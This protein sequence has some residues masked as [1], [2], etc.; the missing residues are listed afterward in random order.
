MNSCLGLKVR[1]KAIRSLECFPV[2]PVTFY[3][4]WQNRVIQ[5]PQAEYLLKKSRFLIYQETNK[6]I[7]S[8]WNICFG[9]NTCLSLKMEWATWRFGDS[10][11]WR[12]HGSS[13]PFP[14]TLPYA[15]LPSGCSSVIFLNCFF[16]LTQGHAYWFYKA[17]KGGRERN[18]NVSNIDQLPFAQVL[19]GNEPETFWFMRQHSN[20]LSHTGQ[21]N[22]IL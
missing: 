22:I 12:G 7:D 15:S 1:K 17:G 6:Y 18:I 3:T 2:Y 5:H 19:T 8:G 20:Q 14:H 10:G 9:K 4:L 11:A 21:G 16:P 13:V